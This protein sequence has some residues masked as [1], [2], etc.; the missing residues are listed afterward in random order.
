MLIALG[1]VLMAFN[2]CGG[3]S[4][5]PRDD[6]ADYA[7]LWLIT[8]PAVPQCFPEF[9]LNFTIDA[10]DVRPTSSSLFN[11]VSDWWFPSQPANKQLVSGNVNFGVNTFELVFTRAGRRAR[12]I[13]TAPSA[14]ALVGTWTDTEDAFITGLLCHSATVHATAS[15]IGVQ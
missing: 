4:T 6:R 2:G 1:A 15:H 12:L 5:G 9:S 14:N 7:G 3:D 8:V 13:G 10:D 11:L